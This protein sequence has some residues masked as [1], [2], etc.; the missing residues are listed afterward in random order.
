MAPQSQ[1]HVCHIPWL[2]RSL[3]LQFRRMSP[4]RRPV[5]AAKNSVPGSSL[6][7]WFDL[8]VGSWQFGHPKVPFPAA[9]VEREVRERSKPYS[10]FCACNSGP[11]AGGCGYSGLRSERLE[12][13]APFGP[14]NRGA[15]QCPCRGAGD[16]PPLLRQG[17]TRW[18]Y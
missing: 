15:A 1:R 2:A 13:P 8:C 10:G 14:R 12:L 9:V 18:S 7:D 16:L 5:S 11:W 6:G 17:R 4:F 3:L